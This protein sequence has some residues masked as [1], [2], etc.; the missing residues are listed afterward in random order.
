MHKTTHHDADD[1]EPELDSQ[2]DLY[3]PESEINTQHDAHDSEPELDKKIH[4]MRHEKPN[5]GSA[6]LLSD[7]CLEILVTTCSRYARE[8]YNVFGHN[9]E[10]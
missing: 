6:S 4:R 2:D 7:T 9:V 1:S 10:T 3:D 5:Q 8:H